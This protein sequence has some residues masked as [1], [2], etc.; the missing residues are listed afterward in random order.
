MSP[1][2]RHIYLHTYIYV[3]T[4][5]VLCGEWSWRVW[6]DADQDRSS[7]PEPVPERCEERP[8]EGPA[9]LLCQ[10]QCTH[11]DSTTVPLR[12]AAVSAGQASRDNARHRHLD[13]KEV[14]HQEATCWKEMRK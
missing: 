11:Q 5:A 12:S 9:S 14:Q 13:P 2:T 10:G 1:K 4:G 3:Y 6:K 8:R 7:Q